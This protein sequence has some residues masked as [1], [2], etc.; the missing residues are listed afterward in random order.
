M[1]Y[2]EC[3]HKQLTLNTQI[4]N[5]FTRQRMYATAMTDDK[6]QDSSSVPFVTVN[7]SHLSSTAFLK[8]LHCIIELYILSKEKK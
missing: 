5:C 2:T 3:K 7:V 8:R 1:S 6:Q 4:R